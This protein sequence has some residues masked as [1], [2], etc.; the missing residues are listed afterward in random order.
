MSRIWLSRVVAVV[1]ILA[2]NFAVVAAQGVWSRA[3]W[4]LR[5]EPR[6]PLPLAVVV[7]SIL[8]GPT[9]RLVRLLPR[10]V[11]VAAATAIR[12]KMVVMVVRVVE[13]TSLE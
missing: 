10:L 11:V 8:L 4:P 2:D 9:H 6:I 7:R 3:T 1:E 13:H 5:L 12:S